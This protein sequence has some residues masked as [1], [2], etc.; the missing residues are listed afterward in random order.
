MLCLDGST[1]SP[2]PTRPGY[3]P[4]FLS[5]APPQVNI[6]NTSGDNLS[7]TTVAEL[8]AEIAIIESLLKGMFYDYNRF[9]YKYMCKFSFSII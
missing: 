5:P 6:S 8:A 9:I 2:L 3:E 1:N 7:D 4:E